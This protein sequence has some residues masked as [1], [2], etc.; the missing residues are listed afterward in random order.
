[1]TRRVFTSESER[2]A[3]EAEAREEYCWTGVY[4]PPI[5][6]ELESYQATRY[7]QHPMVAAARRPAPPVPAGVSAE[8]VERV[9]RESTCTGEVAR[10]LRMAGADMP[11]VLAAMR[12]AERRL[13]AQRP[14]EGWPDRAHGAPLETRLSLRVRE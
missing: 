5:P 6:R 1:M 11:T 7:A 13:E 4:T 2:Q 10:E 14:G 3:A 9:V 12:T 8:L